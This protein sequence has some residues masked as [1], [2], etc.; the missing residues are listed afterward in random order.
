MMSAPNHNDTTNPFGPSTNNSYIQSSFSDPDWQSHSPFPLPSTDEYM[1]ERSLPA[2]DNIHHSIK[3][4]MQPTQFTTPYNTDHAEI[5]AAESSEFPDENKF[6]PFIGDIT[7]DDVTNN[8]DQQHLQAR[9]NTDSSPAFIGD[10]S[11]NSISTRSPTLGCNESYEENQ[12]LALS[13]N[14]DYADLDQL[15]DLSTLCV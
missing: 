13:T 11:N 6:M 9:N 2:H 5:N 7:K 15:S 3:W 12:H 4:E 14:Q 1:V 10:T 8:D